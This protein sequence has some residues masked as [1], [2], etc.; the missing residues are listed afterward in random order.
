MLFAGTD[1]AALLGQLF[2]SNPNAKMVQAAFATTQSNDADLRQNIDC[3]LR[4]RRATDLSEVAT[5]QELGVKS[6]TISVHCT[7]SA[8]T[9]TSS[10]SFE[11]RSARLPMRLCYV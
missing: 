9:E 4:I 11:S 5:I 10:D 7:V 3:T 8:A 6:T 2:K 1:M